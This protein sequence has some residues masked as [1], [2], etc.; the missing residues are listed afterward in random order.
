M[1][2]FDLYRIMGHGID[3]EAHDRNLV[4][5]KTVFQIAHVDVC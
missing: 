3:D 5:P 1:L 2:S 4:I